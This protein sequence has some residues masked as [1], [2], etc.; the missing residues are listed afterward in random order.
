MYFEKPTVS[1]EGG[2]K[3]GKEEGKEGRGWQEKEERGRRKVIG[4]GCQSYCLNTSPFTP[5]QDAFPLGEI[6]MGNASD[7]FSVDENAPYDL[8]GG[9]NAFVLNT[10][11]RTYPLL[12]ETSEEKVSWIAVLRAAIERV[13][14]LPNG[15]GSVND[16]YNTE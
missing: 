15:G 12:A 7:G 6:I 8:G 9:E 2:R 1:F 11:L 3:G 10:P 4:K 16:T 13:S 5:I 14:S